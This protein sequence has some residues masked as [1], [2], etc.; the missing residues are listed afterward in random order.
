MQRRSTHVIDVSG[1]VVV[2]RF[3]SW[4]RDEHRREWDALVL[5][6]AWAPGLAPEPL[7]ANLSGNPPTVVMSRLEGQPLEHPIRPAQLKAMVETVD[8]LHRAVPGEVLR[9]FPVRVG[10]PG[11]FSSQIRAQCG[12]VPPLGPDLVVRQAFEAG[13]AWIDRTTV[14]DPD[15]GQVESVFGL[16]DGN[17]A[18]CLW[19]GERVRLVDFENSGRSDRA[20]ELADIS[21]HLSTWL[22]AG[23]D[24]Q[25]F[26]ANFDLTARE[27]RRLRDARR[28]F[29]LFW[30][31]MLLPGRPAAHRNPPGTLAQQAHRLLTLLD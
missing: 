14:P 4:N 10:A 27:N 2:K 3:Q 13:S 24:A 20:F 16:A 22:G 29:A 7:N 17:L 25:V 1:D 15:D 18:N 12:E 30:L 21:E 23:V 5:L 31:L 11:E 6:M 26:L 19:D 9:T 8:A 28:L